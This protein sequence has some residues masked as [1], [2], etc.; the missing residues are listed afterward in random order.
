MNEQLQ[1]PNE[2]PGLQKRLLL[3][4]ALTFVIIL[5]TQPLLRKFAPQVLE[6]PKQE[7]NQPAAGGGQPAAN[8]A[9]PGQPSPTPQGAAAG[10]KPPAASAQV[11]QAAGESEVVVENDL[12]KITFTN[13][14]AQVKSWVLKKYTD[15]HG[16]PLDL[17]NRLAA[18]KYGYPLSLF[19][20]DEALKNELN[21]ALY[22]P[23]LTGEH[24]APAEVSFEFADGDVSARKTFR[25]D[26][27]YVVKVETGVTR[28]GS[29]VT[30]YPAW[31]G[32]FGDE[33]HPTSYAGGRIDYYTSEKIERLEP[34][35]VAGGATVQPPFYWAG[36]LD[37]YFAAIFLPDEPQRASLV[38]LHGEIGLPEDLNKPDP[39]K[40]IKVP[41]LGAA[42]GTMGGPSST[43]LFVGPKA[44]D[45]LHGVRAA[46][47]APGSVGPDIEGALDWGFFGLIAKPLFLW[48]KWTHAHWIPNWGWAIVFLTVIINA[49]LFP[50]RLSS[51]KS[52]MKMQKIAPQV[53][54]L[55]DKYKKYKLND[56]RRQEQNAELAALYKQHGVNPVGGCFPLLLQMPFLFAF[57]TMLANATELRH[58]NWLWVRDLAGPDPWHLL[59][60]GIIVTMFL[61]Q[62]LTP[63]GGMDPMQQKMMM[64]M[65]P[66]MLGWISWNL[67]AGLSLY[68]A[69]GNLLAI[70]Q[71]LWINN[72]E[73]GR[74]MR[75]ARAPH[76]PRK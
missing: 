60:V 37:Q 50:L 14:G 47:T 59:P 73:F 3:V 9:A 61:T 16:K 40:T 28:G 53:K 49:A 58:A 19:A 33:T 25:F 69:V 45:V 68:W 7:Q 8:P 54:A 4:F 22:V 5:A 11:K 26:H 31:P 43:R 1:N 12:Y 39:N 65:M 27:S 35:K 42:V 13:R 64:V 51:M 44:I 32:G 62:K 70:A 15:D 71:Q 76:K 52:A 21:S 63:Q 18:E 10:A 46:G 23:S 41:V 67:A 38:L 17:V 20:Y 56:P 75:A 30:A 48:L 29:Y 24:E 74:E 72:T 6:P 57:Y 55:Q 36:T 34:K 2:D 66:V